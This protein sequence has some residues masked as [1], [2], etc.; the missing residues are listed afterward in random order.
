[1]LVVVCGSKDVDGPDG[2]AVVVEVV[3]AAEP[4][5]ED[6]EDSSRFRDCSGVLLE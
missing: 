5:V 4:D 1:M 2:L 3:A 6:E